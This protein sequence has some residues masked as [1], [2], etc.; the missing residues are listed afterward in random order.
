MQDWRTWLAGLATESGV[1][2]VEACSLSIKT[3]QQWVPPGAPNDTTRDAVLTQ[4]VHPDPRALLA[5][6][7]S[8]YPPRHVQ[9]PPSPAH[10][11][12]RT[13]L[14]AGFTPRDACSA[15]S[16]ESAT[17][18]PTSR[19]LRLRV[20]TRLRPLARTSA[21]LVAPARA[22]L[23]RGEEMGGTESWEHGL[24]QQRGAHRERERE[25]VARYACEAWCAGRREG[26]SLCQSCWTSC[27]LRAPTS[28]AS[29][30]VLCTCSASPLCSSFCDR[31]SHSYPGPSRPHRTS[32]RP[33]PHNRKVPANPSASP[34]STRPSV[35][36]TAR[37]SASSGAASRAPTAT[38]ASS[39]P[40]SPP[41][42]RPRCS[43]RR[44]ASCSSPRTSKS[45]VRPSP[46]RHV[47]LLS[48]WC[49]G[50]E[51]CIAQPQGSGTR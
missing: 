12:Y 16:V 27:L 44:A 14:R 6:E 23:E 21:R 32:P 20:L 46:S 5:F 1:L 42:S 2:T 24:G 15:T 17:R 11:R 43:A 49:W 33:S 34:T 18:A 40:S 3:Q 31:P 4:N 35:R 25:L 22:R 47:L 10:Y 9:S 36:S 39:S 38:R 19:S 48:G 7:P 50:G 45:D 37:V 26:A 8:L 29:H 41:T 51:P 30:T 28:C 13:C